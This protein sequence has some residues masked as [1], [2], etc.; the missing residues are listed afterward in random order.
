MGI[1]NR[2]GALY[3]A[4]GID[5]SGLKQGAAEAEKIIDDIGKRT[6]DVSEKC[7]VRAK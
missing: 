7:N 6:E 3:M 4:T 5:K 1:I 2:E